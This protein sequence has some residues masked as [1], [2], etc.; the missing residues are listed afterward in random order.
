MTQ[1]RLVLPPPFPDH[2][3]LPESEIIAYRCGTVS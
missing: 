3:Q 1:T 2:S